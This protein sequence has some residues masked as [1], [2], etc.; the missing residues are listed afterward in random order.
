MKEDLIATNTIPSRLRSAMVL[1]LLL[2]SLVPA[3]AAGPSDKAKAGASMVTELMGL[4]QREF[5]YETTAPK[6]VNS[7]IDGL[8]A[9]LSEK[10]IDSADLKHVEANLSTEEAYTA[11]TNQFV[12]MAALHPE[13]MKDQWL[14]YTATVSM[15]KV[16]DDPYTVFLSPSEYQKLKE[17]MSGGNFGGLGI[18]IE[19]DEKNEKWLTVVE[20]IEDTPASRAGLKPRDV[21]IKIDGKS[22]KG[23]TVDQA[24]SHLRGKPGSEVTLTIRRKNAGDPFD[25]KLKRE[26]IQVATVRGNLVEEKAHK[27]GYVKLRLFGEKTNQELEAT[28]RE[29]EAQGAEAFVLDIRNNGGGYIGTAVDVCSKFLPTGSRVVTV[30]ERAAGET[31]YDS[32]PNMRSTVPLVILVNE[33]SA[34]ASEITAGAIQDLQAGKLVGMKTFG[35]GSVQK[36]YPLPDGSAIKVTTAHYLTPAGKDLHKKGVEP[37]IKVE[38]QGDKIGTSEDVQLK[39]AVEIVLLDLPE[40]ASTAGKV[41]PDAIRVS[42]VAEQMHYLESYQI[43]DRKVRNED[44]FLLEEVRVKDPSGAEKTI[45]FDISTMLGQ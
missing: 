7:T 26:I 15:L 10:K 21:I 11:F 16:L 39:K 34:S 3:L 40:T 12:Q 45:L 25:V 13:L 42:S 37:D 4:V 8:R 30:N 32:R 24:Q 23:F 2:A 1:V 36:I 17:Q 20:P 18:Y 31:R 28:M 19:L 35:K 22:T 9:A 29:L 38:M 6:L 41:F 14:T 43:L 44:G 33:Y 27:I 5:I